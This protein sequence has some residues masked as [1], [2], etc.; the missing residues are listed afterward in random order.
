MSAAPAAVFI[1]IRPV[2]KSFILL[3]LQPFY[4][5]TYLLRETVTD[6]RET[7]VGPYGLEGVPNVVV[8][9]LKGVCKTRNAPCSAA[10]A[11]HA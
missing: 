6:A 8:Q 5:R 4:M 9:I 10:T 2:S 1:A 3:R 7:V 11:R